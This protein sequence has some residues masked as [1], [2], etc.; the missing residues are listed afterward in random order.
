MLGHAWYFYTVDHCKSSFNNDYEKGKLTDTTYI[1]DNYLP[2]LKPMK[3]PTQVLC[4][5]AQV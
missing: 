2:T 3:V 5:C 4:S 1:I